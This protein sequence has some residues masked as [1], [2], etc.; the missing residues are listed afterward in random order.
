MMP[1]L[2]HRL[3]D[4]FLSSAD[5]DAV[6][7]DLHERGVTGLRLWRETT[8]AL[9]HLRDRTARSDELMS[10]FLSDLRLA[11]RL[12]ARAPT[13]TAAAVLTL[14]IAIGAATA[15]FSVANPV[16][17]QPLPYHKPDRVVVVW[18][19]DQDGGRSTVGFAT[20]RDYM[21][22]ATTFESAAALGFWLPTLLDRTESERLQGLRVSAT[23]FNTLGVRPALGRDFRADED[24][25]GVP[26]VVILSHTLWQRRFGGDSAMIGKAI[27]IGSTPMTVVGVMPDGFD[28][29]ALPGAQIWRVL[30]Y[31]VTDS[32][33]CRTCR[34]LRMIARLEEGVT[35]E[36]AR[37]ELSTIHRAIVAEHPK[38][39]ASVGAEVVPLQEEVT[40]DYRSAILALGAAVVL[41]LIIAIANVANLQLARLVRREEEFAIRT[42]LGASS[43]RI[44]R[45]LL[46]EALVIAVLGGLAGVAVAAAAIPALV[47]QLPPALPR[48]GAIHLDFAALAVVGGIV[49]LLA[50]V[51]GLVPRRGRRVGNIADGLRAGRRMT[52][53]RHS[54]VRAGLVVTELAFAL[55]L[56]VGA[57]LL[58][59]S[60]VRL[61]N[62]DKG[63]D[64]SNL[65]TLEINSVGS[66]YADDE[67][68]ARYHDRVREAVRNLPGVVGVGVVNQ[69]P[70]GGNMDR[71]GVVAYDK[72]SA[73]PELVPSGD[74]YVISADYLRTMRTRVIEGRAFTE[75]EERDTTNLVALVSQALAARLWPGESAI[76]KRIRMGGPDRPFRTVIGVTAN[77]RHS[78]LDATETMQFYVPERQWFFSDNQE[79]L[80][81]RTKGDPVAIA[82][83]VRRAIQ[84]IDP[85]QPILNVASMEQVIA[86]STAQRRLA[87]TLFGCFAIAAVLLAVAGIYGVLAGNVA[88]RTR[89][90]GLRA[91]LGATPRNILSLIVG[92]GARLAVAGLALGLFGSFALTRTLRALLFGIGPNDPMTIAVATLL[93][94]ITTLAA[95]LV[96]AAR[97]LRVDPSL[98]FRA[99]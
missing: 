80:V 5:A 17:L 48:L 40:R 99:D 95:C 90:I 27:S 59:R 19:R 85:V 89:E 42:A 28:D 49:M 77:V 91:A 39:Y 63:F 29:V 64:A 43:P 13:F 2:P 96:P 73:N 38:D 34:H 55:M 6:I 9:W 61:L 7:G 31:G 44:S 79:V 50:V 76:G 53:T 10:S 57:G 12:L 67:A 37:T 47:R 87:L 30:G 71:Y 32:Y 51:V 60:V 4:R 78:G 26:P 56:L 74:R 84:Q 1:P 35:V 86:A 25:P 70:L 8:V 16:I 66:R 18:E 98:A 11:F 62:V 82:G 36:R 21:D 22:R 94:L 33:A 81:V 97:A 72:P 83:A 52:G 69:L 68:V 45:Q 65:L 92:H 46:T 20:I 93:L 15:I 75:A 41:M 54:A 3:L 58:A 88:E 23:Y 24:V 14:G